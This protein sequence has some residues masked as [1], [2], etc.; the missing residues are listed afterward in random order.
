MFNG[1]FPRKLLSKE[2]EILNKVLPQSKSGYQLYRERIKNYYIVGE[3]NSEN[4]F[5]LAKDKDYI[6]SL[7]FITQVFAAGTVSSGDKIIDITIQEELDETIEFNLDYLEKG[8]EYTLF[9]YSDWVPGMKAPGDGSF[10]REI[11][12]QKDKYL[13]AILPAHKKILLYEFETGIV[14]FLSPGAFYNALCFVKNIRE[15]ETVF[16][17]GLLF[18]NIN[19]FFDDE[20]AKAFY[21]YNK[22][23]NRFKLTVPQNK[24]VIKKKFF[25]KN[26]LKKDRN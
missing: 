20:L 26:I 6:N 11:I 22:G 16:N 1:P 4:S 3:G 7:P 17:P 21:I 25:L 14:H 19:S 15:P 24:E 18:Q 10:I 8:E 13:L 2:I 12:L 23:F 9:T 5:I